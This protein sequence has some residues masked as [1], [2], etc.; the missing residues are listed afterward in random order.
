MEL[1][2][3][4]IMS[5]DVNPMVGGYL[6]SEEIYKDVIDNFGQPL[7]ILE[8]GCGPG[9]NLAKFEQAY[10]VGI[11]PLPENVNRA[12]KA[13]VG[14]VILGDHRNLKQFQDNQ[15]DVGITCSVLDHIENFQVALVELVRVCKNLLLIE[16]VKD[17][18]P[19]QAMPD[20]TKFWKTTWYH[21]YKKL[22]VGL[23]LK[24]S[25]TKSPLRKTNSGPFYRTYA[26]KCEMYTIDSRKVLKPLVVTNLA[27][28]HNIGLHGNFLQQ[29][30]LVGIEPTFAGGSM[31]GIDGPILYEKCS[32]NDML[33]KTKANLLL[34]YRGGFDSLYKVPVL[35]KKSLM[36]VKIPIVLIDVDFCFLREQEDFVSECS[37]I[38]L[39]RHPIDLEYSK[40]SIKEAFPFSIDPTI[41]K[42]R[43]LRDREHKLCFNGK[44]GRKYGIRDVALKLMPEIV[45]KAIHGKSKALIPEQQVK[46]YQQHVAA[47]GE[48][49]LPW[50]YLVA[51]HFEIP[52][53]GTI[54]FTN[55]N[56]GVENYLYPETFVK[57]KDDCSD[58]REKFHN[59][60]EHLDDWQ[61]KTEMAANHVLT[62]HSNQNRWNQFI[63][64]INSFLGESY[65]VNYEI[66][67]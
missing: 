38:H 25:E 1:G 13:M 46:F 30:T 41:Y 49:A 21:D 9:G 66:S 54:L 31:G 4:M 19:R 7:S 17:G 52:A 26:V 48:N 37:Q 27:K 10:R 34:L 20:E 36:S 56:N 51:K 58:L 42:Y 61:I 50:R 29:S 35:D 24:F 16:P 23:G 43:N 5:R 12:K 47:L 3:K 55:G 44:T 33:D 14:E 57:F 15:F 53:T 28:K 32:L 63:L 62:Q 60:L 11:D 8:L 39:L 22:L 64:N 65:R 67:E 18:Q 2:R 59:I 6:F 40:C 45:C